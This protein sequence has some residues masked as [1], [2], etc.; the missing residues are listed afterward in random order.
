M[1]DAIKFP[2]G[3]LRREWS[4]VQV[5]EYKRASLLV[6]RK[7]RELAWQPKKTDGECN[8]NDCNES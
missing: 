1:N 5:N 2:E 7:T 8:G 4:R 3:Q 6:K